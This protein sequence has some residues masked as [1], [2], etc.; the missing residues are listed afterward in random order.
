MKL[1]TYQA[2]EAKLLLQHLRTQPHPLRQRRRRL[3]ARRNGNEYLDLLSGIGVNALGYG[4]PAIEEAIATQSKKLIHTSNLFFHEHTAELALRLTEI[5]GLDRVFFCNSGTE[6]WE[7]ALKLARAHAG[8]CAAKAATSARSS[9][10]SNT[11]STAAPW[12]PSRPPTKKSTASPSLPS[13]PVSSSSA[14]TTSPISAQSSPTKS[15]PSASSPFR[16]KAASPRLAGVLRGRSRALRLHRRAAHR[17]RDPVRPRPHRQVVRLSALRHPA[18][19][20]HL[21]K[22]LAGGIPSARC[23]APK[24][25]RAI[26]SRHARHHLRRRPAGLRRGHRR[27]RQIKKTTCSNT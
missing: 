2:A 25:R 7:A 1:K 14:S 27:H 22:P 11:A 21:A 5:T 3:P 16:A 19:C 13:C 15:A 23:S 9:S 6:A 26:H 18:R 10:R 8:C 20:H 12:A 24:S 17:R 4:H